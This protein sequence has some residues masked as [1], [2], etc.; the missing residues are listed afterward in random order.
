MKSKKVN[1]EIS[2]EMGSSCTTVHYKLLTMAKLMALKTVPTHR[3]HYKAHFVNLPS[4][5][6]SRGRRVKITGISPLSK[7]L[8]CY[9]FFSFPPL[10]FQDFLSHVTW[11]MGNWR[12][13]SQP[14]LGHQ[15]L[16]FPALGASC[17]HLQTNANKH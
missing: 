5:L 2:V 11:N 9:F 3:Q 15:G 12:T 8:L 13:L 4:F 1:A 14:C 7:L 6:Y 16:S 10:S 17:A